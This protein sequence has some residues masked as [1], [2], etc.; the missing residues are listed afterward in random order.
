MKIRALLKFFTISLALAVTFSVISIY[1]LRWISETSTVAHRQEFAT[2][3]AADF[4]QKPIAEV[5]NEV[6]TKRRLQI[7]IVDQQGRVMTA[8]PPNPI[9]I[10]WSKFERPAEP[11]DIALIY[12]SFDVA[13]RYTVVRLKTLQPLYLIYQVGNRRGPGSNSLIL[14]QL[15]VTF[16]LLLVAT[17]F[18]FSMTFIYLQKKSR[19]ASAVLAQIEKGDLKA[20]FQIDRIDEFGHLMLDFNRMAEQIEKLVADLK[21]SEAARR[22]LIEELSHDLRTPLTSLTTALETLANHFDKMVPE[23]RNELFNLAQAELRYLLRMIEDLF[24]TAKL[25]DPG[26]QL[27]AQTVELVGLLKGEIDRRKGFGPSPI[28]WRYTGPSDAAYQGDEYLLQRLFRNL[29]DNAGRFAAARVDVGLE[30]SE[31]QP[32]R[33]R[34]KITIDDDGPGMKPEEIVAFGTR[35]KQRIIPADDFSKTSLGLGSVIA[36]SVAE[37]HGG[38]IEIKDRR[39]LNKNGTRVLIYL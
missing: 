28:E 21:R 1:T 11:H 24:L 34:F 32:G 26:R 22:S 9:P 6:A 20:R 27:Q 13:P 4:E 37:M 17:F 29:L 35:H 7:W 39:T 33:A 23:D 5:A 14:Q 18:A 3:I 2:N 36:K 31:S 38:R 30:M 10:D 16:V 25:E 12:N 19:E 8:A 15:V